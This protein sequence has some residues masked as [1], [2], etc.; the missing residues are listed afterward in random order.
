MQARALPRI[1]EPTEES[2]GRHQA[3][4]GLFAVPPKGG[5]MNVKRSL[6]QPSAGEGEAHAQR[7]KL[8]FPCPPCDPVLSVIQALSPGPSP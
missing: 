6:R 3:S 7:A 1:T 4:P 2:H 5:T 8:V